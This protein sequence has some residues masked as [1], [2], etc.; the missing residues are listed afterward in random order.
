MKMKRTIWMVAGFL[1]VS[2]AAAHASVSV[3][4]KDKKVRVALAGKD[5][6]ELYGLLLVEEKQPPHQAPWRVKSLGLAQLQIECRRLPVTA[7]AWVHDCQVSYRQSK[8][9]CVVDSGKYVSY[10][11]PTEAQAE[12][13]W[14]LF[15]AKEGSTVGGWP[16]KG[17]R[18]TQGASP[19]DALFEISCAKDRPASPELGIQAA[20]FACDFSTLVEAS[21][22]AE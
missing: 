12:L 9:A 21:S 17:W 18:L 1:V 13:F 6:E 22:C 15:G 2:M 19:V 4:V 3:H 14:K 10:A 8:P 11:L 16:V 20:K 7:S 5:A